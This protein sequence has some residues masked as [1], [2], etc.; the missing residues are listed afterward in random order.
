MN[1]VLLAFSGGLDTSFCA[2]YLA[3]DMGMEVHTVLVD[4]GGFSSVDIENIASRAHACGVASH[5]TLDRTH[6]LFDN[7]LRYCIAGNV[8]KNGT[9][10]LSVSAERVVQAIAIAEHAR[11]IGA[12]HIAHG[13]TGAGNDQIRFDVIFRIMCPE[14]AVITPIRDKKLSRDEEIA[15]LTKHGVEGDWTKSAYSINQGIWGT[16]IGGRET[17]TSHE[18]LPNNAWP[19]STYALD[20]NATAER[21]AITFE[22]GLPVALNEVVMSSLD[23][24]KRLNEIGSR[25]HIGRD[26]HVGD[27]ILGIK[28]RVAFEAPA[29][30]MTIKAHHTLEKHALT[31]WQLML[32]DQLSLWYGQLLHEGQF[33]EPVMRDIEAFFR[34]TQQA[35]SGT[36]HL[37]CSARSFGILGIESAQDLMKSSFATYGEE[38]KAWDGMDARGFA[39]INAISTTLW[40]SVN[41]GDQ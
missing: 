20:P 36:V 32:K 9:Y 27:T 41:G 37:E 15:Y 31:K 10:P 19:S 40:R 17:L 4:T 16:T 18:P 13:S 22:K 35:V 11:T 3:V 5:M 26:M 24:I 8:L 6:E 38:N 14:L 39:T 28:G 12:T 29:A 1:K 21:I 2:R 34:T 23:V 30:L 7:V 25:W 33:L